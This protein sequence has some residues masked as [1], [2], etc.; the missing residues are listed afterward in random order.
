MDAK[1]EAI[2]LEVV[3]LKELIGN[4]SKHANQVAQ[5]VEYGRKAQSLRE[6]LIK[7]QKTKDYP[8]EEGNVEE[9]NDWVQAVVKNE[10][11]KIEMNVSASLGWGNGAFARENVKEREVLLKF[12]VS[13]ILRNRPEEYTSENTFAGKMFKVSSLYRQVESAQLA[14]NLL[15]EVR[16]GKQSKFYSYVKCLPKRFETL[17]ISWNLDQ[18]LLLKETIIMVQVLMRFFDMLFFYSRLFIQ[19]KVDKEIMFCT[20]SD[21]LWAMCIV[22]TRQNPLRLTNTIQV[23][24]L[25]P[26]FDMCNHDGGGAVSTDQSDDFQ[27]VVTYAW[28]DFNKGEEVTIFYGARSTVEFFIFSGFIPLEKKTSSLSVIKELSLTAPSS[29]TTDE[30]LFTAKRM[31]LRNT[32][33]LHEASSTTNNNRFMI[34]LNGDTLKALLF[35]AKVELLT[36]MDKVKEELALKL[37]QATV[38][39]KEEKLFALKVLKSFVE[40][41]DQVIANVQNQK[42]TPPVKDIV[43]EYYASEKFVLTQLLNSPTLLI[44]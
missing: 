42:Q 41:Y 3:A 13:H 33:G 10:P 31:L 39:S 23:L 25:I 5:L 44:A 11:N 22:S 38:Y 1:E 43:C 4:L 12:P 17:P 40:K 15:H 32:P 24:G 2:L 7:L 19:D 27:W 26:L 18:I 35:F 14:L 20:F 37:K 21:F 29:T 16:L 36:S 9:F 6:E 34:S 8:V 30:K 28:K